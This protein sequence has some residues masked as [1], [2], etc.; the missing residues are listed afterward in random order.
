MNDPQ[1]PETTD[2]IPTLSACATVM[3]RVRGRALLFDIVSVQIG[4]ALVQPSPADRRM[5]SGAAS[6]A[7]FVS[8]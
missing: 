2:E 6:F 7:D 8:A 3:A 1:F 4:R 5:L